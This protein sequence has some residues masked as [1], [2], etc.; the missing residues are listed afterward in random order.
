MKPITDLTMVGLLMLAVLVVFPPEAGADCIVD[1]TAGFV[2]FWRAWEASW[3]G[4]E[5][6]AIVE[7]AFNYWGIGDQPGELPTLKEEV[8][9]DNP[10]IRLT[11]LK[12]Q[13]LGKR[14]ALFN[15]HGSDPLWY[16]PGMAVEYY[17]TAHA[18]DSACQY[19]YTHGYEYDELD[20]GVLWPGLNWT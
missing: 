10:E 1:S 16:P 4:D 14:V 5:T 8:L 13:L 3:C 19:Y 2:A 9:D 15:T 20:V 11:Q 12:T 7:G 18:A 6:E 17:R